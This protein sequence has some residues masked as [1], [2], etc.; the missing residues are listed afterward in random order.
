[1]C[2]LEAASYAS[3]KQFCSLLDHVANG[4]EYD[5]RQQLY[6]YIDR[7]SRVIIDNRSFFVV[8]CL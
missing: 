2:Y 1:M 4:P 8:E 7:N 3:D 6:Q 5:E